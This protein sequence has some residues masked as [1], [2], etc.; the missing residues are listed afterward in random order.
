MRLLILDEPRCIIQLENKNRGDAVFTGMKSLE[1]YKS[2]IEDISDER[3]NRD[4]IWVYLKGWET[5]EGM[6]TIHEDTVRACIEKL[7][8]CKK[9]EG[10]VLESKAKGKI[11]TYLRVS[12][13]DQTVEN[14]RMALKKRGFESDKEFLD[15]GLTGTNLD[16]KG[17]LD[18][19]NYVRRGDV[20]V[21]YSFSRI[22]RS[23]KDLLGVV[24]ELNKKEVELISISENVDT[25]TPTGKLMVTMLG[26]MAQ[27]EV[28][29]MK[30]RQA[31]GIERA[32][33]EGKY[34][35]RKEIEYPKEWE[36]YYKRW[37]SKEITSKE[38]MEN[39]GLK[40]TTF[41]K[42]KK[43]YEGGNNDI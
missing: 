38:F 14:Q 3:G 17:L 31:I 6:E 39:M 30:E 37:E 22:A 26:A 33:K 20:V 40:K 29:V 19:I 18:M 1:K 42:L 4:G 43:Q 16:R 21:T 24:E 36:F 7:K 9:K 23:T 2:R 34:K 28:E 13:K 32:K 27:F 10:V 35:G 15:E 8:G 41:F 5:S 11:I 25:S 12:T